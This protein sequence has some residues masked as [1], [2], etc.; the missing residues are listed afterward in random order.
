MWSRKPWPQAPSYPV[1][2]VAVKAQVTGVVE[3]LFVEAGQQV[4]KGQLVAR[5]RVIP[6]ET[7]L[8]NGRENVKAARIAA[9]AAEIERVRQEK[10]FRDGTVAEQAYLQVKLD[11]EQAQQRL[12]A[13]E[14]AL[15]VIRTGAAKG[16]KTAA[17]LVR[18]TADGM[19]LDVPVEKGNSVISANNFNEGT[20]VISVAD[21]SE[22]VFEGK[23][24]ESEVGKLVEGMALELTIGA[25]D[26]RI[27]P[28]TL[29]F[30]AP[31]GINEEGTIK[32]EIRASVELPEDVFLRAGYSANADIVL[33]SKEAVLLI[34]EAWLQF[35][36]DTVFVE[37]ESSEQ[38]FEREDVKLG[39]SDG[40]VV[41]LL[42]G[43]D[44]T[45]A[46]KVPQ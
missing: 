15:E 17:N 8:Q 24:D 3:E 29:D 41:E 10:L 35:A 40:L 12:K 34:K 43:P 33:E 46:I 20:T 11:A 5:I 23:V 39:L 21:M 25:V 4:S 7:A 9:D 42:E 32:F 27:L 38:V 22:M 31:K 16:S 14:S 37:V 1:G 36:G 26:E 30:I 18:A 19:V 45:A 6:D 13:A 28:A 44:S 2:E